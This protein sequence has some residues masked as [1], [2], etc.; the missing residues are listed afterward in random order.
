MISIKKLRANYQLRFPFEK[1]LHDFIKSL[2][3]DQQKTKMDLIKNSDGT[4]KEDWYRV[5]N[6]AGLIK[7]IIYLKQNNTKFNFENLTQ[8]ELN[9]LVKVYKEKINKI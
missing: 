3:K 1:R 6:E 9:Y 4:T 8:D 5:I 2:P 7:I